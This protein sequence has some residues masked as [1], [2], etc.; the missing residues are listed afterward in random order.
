MANI[1][2]EDI[3]RQIFAQR[4]EKTALKLQSKFQTSF[5]IAGLSQKARQE[6]LRKIQK[7]FPPGDDEFLWLNLLHDLWDS[8]YFECK[9]IALQ[10]LFIQD[11]RVDSNIWG[12]LDHWTDDIDTWILAD[13]LGHV[14]AIAN[15]KMPYLIMRL[16]VWLQ[17]LNPMRRRSAL[18][19]LVHVSP[20]NGAC[21][22]IL[23]P[24]EII[25]FVEPVIGD[26]DHNV[27]PAIAWILN[28]IK[29]RSPSLF[30]D[31][32]KNVQT[33]LDRNVHKLLFQSLS[34]IK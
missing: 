4:D 20:E 5:H 8:P 21:K 6:F 1:R 23:R 14:R 16:A 25:A 28:L 34:D 30:A 10:L 32:Y 7:D 12:T 17:S 24:Q 19:S 26:Q 15:N 29:E 9:L 27:S 22:L 2:I 3:E 31:Y 11:E 18:V 33:Q 13:W